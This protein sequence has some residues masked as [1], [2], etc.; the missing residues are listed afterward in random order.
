MPRTIPD[1]IIFIPTS[2]EAVCMHEAGHV[3]MAYYRECDPISVCLIEQ[4]TL[5]GKTSSS[6]TT[7]DAKR[8]IA[9][10]AF[11]VELK[12]F[13]KGRLTNAAGHVIIDE[14]VFV[15]QANGSQA[16]SD[17]A[18]FLSASGEIDDPVKE[19]ETDTRFMATGMQLAP[20]V[21]MDQVEAIANA[22]LNR[23]SLSDADV[24]QIM[25]AFR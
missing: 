18:S 17:K 13:Q 14:T 3:L 24:K 25:A 22:L 20:H 15:K 12:L 11:A 16:V 7:G 8:T 10:G 6:A 21:R 23:R 5:H 1:K 2:E 19:A 9:C 4:P